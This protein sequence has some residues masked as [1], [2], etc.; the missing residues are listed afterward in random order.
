MKN[1]EMSSTCWAFNK[2]VGNFSKTSANI[3]T[4]NALSAG[5]V[6]VNK[7]SNFSIRSTIGREPETMSKIEM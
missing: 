3:F 1:V 7:K 4:P 5:D 2:S 6:F